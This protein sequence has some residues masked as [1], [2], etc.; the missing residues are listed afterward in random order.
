[1]VICLMT[2]RD[3]KRS[4]S[5]SIHEWMKISCKP[6]EIGAQYEMT[7]GE[8]NCHAIEIQDGGVAEVCTLWVFFF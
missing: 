3:P 6:L 7:Y 5:C 8:S 4:R 1:M 2:S